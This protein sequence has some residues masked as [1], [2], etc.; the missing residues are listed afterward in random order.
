[1]SEALENIVE[2]MMRRGNMSGRIETKSGIVVLQHLTSNKLFHSDTTH[3]SEYDFYKSGELKVQRYRQY[4]K[5]HRTGGPAVVQ[6]YKSGNTESEKYYEN[7]FLKNRDNL[8][9]VIFYHPNGKIR[10][11][12][13]YNSA[14]KLHKLG[15]PAE[16]L[17][18]E[19]G[20]LQKIAYYR[21]DQLHRLDGPALVLMEGDGIK[22]EEFHENG[23]PKNCNGSPNTIKYKNNIAVYKSW[24][25]EE[26]KYHRTDGP[27]LENYHE[28]GKLS[29][30]YYYN[31]GVQHRLDGPAVTSYSENGVKL[32]ENYYVDDIPENKS[33]PTSIQF[34]PNG[35]VMLEIWENK[36]GDTHQ[37]DHP[38]FRK[39]HE[40]GKIEE[41]QWQINGVIT[42]DKGPAVI[43]WYPNG[44]IRQRKYY[45]NGK[46]YRENE[47]YGSVI[48]Y[49][50]NIANRK[51]REDFINDT[52]ICDT[53]M[54]ILYGEDGSR[55]ICRMK[56]A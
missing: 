9:N 27:A 20:E 46:R 25:D 36:K 34:Y 4:G 37:F 5:L 18:A 47:N 38:A 22:Q 24:R 41:E 55:Q 56:A 1:M 21:D 28:N 10:A 32:S 7:G 8:P 15:G 54:S 23:K 6:F 52:E 12:Y 3:P 16:K 29:S 49:Y 50:E 31:H 2:Y 33:G 14:K 26:S 51:K 48:T 42:R 35:N 13:W 43:S 44:Y 17:Y 53:Y 45:V 39:Y 30:V 19:N 11:E 40:N